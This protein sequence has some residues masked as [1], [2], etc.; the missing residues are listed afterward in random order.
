VEADAGELGHDLRHNPGGAATTTAGFMVVLAPKVT[1]KLS[2][3]TPTA[4]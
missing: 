4:L 2:G 3:L 1:L